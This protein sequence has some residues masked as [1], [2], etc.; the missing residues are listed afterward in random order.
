[1]YSDVTDLKCKYSM[2]DQMQ[3][4]E[5]KRRNANIVFSLIFIYLA[6]SIEVL[7]QETKTRK[8]DISTPNKMGSICILRRVRTMYKL[9][10]S[11]GISYN[12]RAFFSA[13]S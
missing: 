11:C 9:S 10:N 13:V 1:V 6:I 3:F 5:M 7:N 8:T 2:G 4:N 12:S